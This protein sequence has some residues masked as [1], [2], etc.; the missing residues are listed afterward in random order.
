MK[1]W[2]RIRGIIWHYRVILA[3]DALERQQPGTQQWEQ[4]AKRVERLY[5]L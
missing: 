1:L 2:R 3:F 4:A 5:F